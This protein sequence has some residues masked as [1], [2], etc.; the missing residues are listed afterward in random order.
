MTSK[1]PDLT[2]ESLINVLTGQICGLGMDRTGFWWMIIWTLLKYLLLTTIRSK[3]TGACSI[4]TGTYNVCPIFWLYSVPRGL[5]DVS[6]YPALI[7]RL[8]TGKDGRWSEMDV[9]KLMGVNF[10]RVFQQVEGVGTFTHSKSY[11]GKAYLRTIRPRNNF[12]Q[13]NLEF[14]K[15]IVFLT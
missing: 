12:I 3:L 15:N 2:F 7:E 4:F 6:K 10:V 9:K 14:F 13:V 5:E 11:V 8:R 1:T